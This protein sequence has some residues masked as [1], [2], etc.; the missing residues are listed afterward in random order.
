MITFNET[1]QQLSSHLAASM[2]TGKIG[3][4]RTGKKRTRKEAH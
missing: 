4:K 3:K 1:S 2:V